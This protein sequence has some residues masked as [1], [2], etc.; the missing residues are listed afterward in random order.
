MN[1]L[2]TG[3]SGLIGQRV[4]EL[5]LE[6]GHSLV[7]LTR[8]PSFKP[9]PGQKMTGQTL[10]VRDI[11][12][13]GKLPPGLLDGVDGIVNLA[14]EP[15]ASGR[16]TAAK[17]RLILDSRVNMT[18]QLV[19]AIAQSRQPQFVESLLKEI[20][21][22]STHLHK[23]LVLVSAS[24]AGYYGASETA[25]MTESSLPGKDFLAQVCVAWET[26]AKRAESYGV[27]TVPIRFSL[28]ICRGAHALKM[29]VLPFRFFI[30]GPLGN[31]RQWFPW[32][33][34]DDLARLIIQAL[35][36]DSFSG[37]VNAVAPQAIRQREFSAALGRILGRPSWLPV[38]A[39]ALRLLVGE[40]AQVL[41][42]GQHVVSEQVV[43]HGFKFLFPTIESALH[44]SLD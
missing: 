39:F 25:T 3:G 9:S 38:P 13:D 16:W 43:A 20:P 7:L 5:L 18:R 2:I 33:H 11:P 8:N 17:K 19:E 40:Q 31:G 36:D 14:G 4:C 23:P 15:I 21:S 44:E 35:E 41:L 28:V 1:I 42:S 22:G 29:M 10:V 27:R 26:E 34:R 30:G 32:I 24:A 12:A 6:K 37:P